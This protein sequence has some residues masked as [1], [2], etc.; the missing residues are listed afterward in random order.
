[1][2]N[3]NAI[4]NFIADIYVSA[5]PNFFYKEVVYFPSYERRTVVSPFLNQ[6]DVFVDQIDTKLLEEQ[7]ENVGERSSACFFFKS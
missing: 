1:M 2:S 3:V 5:N 6:T 7:A 4:L